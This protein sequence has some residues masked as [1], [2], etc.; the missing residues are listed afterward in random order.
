MKYMQIA[1]SG[2]AHS[3]LLQHAFC[4]WALS[5]PDSTADLTLI[6]LGRVCLPFCRNAAHDSKLT[7]IPSLEGRPGYWDTVKGWGL[8]MCQVRAVHRAR[9]QGVGCRI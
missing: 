5:Y 9:V 3:H 8:G 6:I 7:H 4:L 1:L 2:C